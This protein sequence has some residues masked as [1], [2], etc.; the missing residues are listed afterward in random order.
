MIEEQSEQ[1]GVPIIA[2]LLGLLIGASSGLYY[3]WFVNP[4]SLTN[5]TPRQLDQENLEQY[6][7]LISEAYLADEDLE[8]AERRLRTVDN[9]SPEEIVAQLA[10][11]GFSRGD[12]PNNV[13]ALTILAE[14]LGQSPRAAEVFSGIVAPTSMPRGTPTATFRPAGQTT[15]TPTRTPRP[16]QPTIEST[17]PFI[18]SELEFISREVR[19]NEDENVG[20]LEI[21]VLDSNGSGLP[22]LPIQVAWEDRSE[23]FYTGFKPELGAGFADFQMEA[24]LIYSVEILNLTEPVGG[25]DSSECTTDTNLLSIPNYRLIFAPDSA[26][27]EPSNADEE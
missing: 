5:I 24:N 3:A 20:L 11:E 18:E 7:L 21:I 4:V 9:E 13:R 26:V 22:G 25:I 23:I 14:A 27:I 17:E 6:V 2:V 10:D 16:T 8:R 12:D 1:G 19:C 15:V